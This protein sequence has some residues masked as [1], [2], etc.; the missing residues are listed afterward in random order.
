MSALETQVGGTHYTTAKD[1]IDTG[2]ECPSV[3]YK[4]FQVGAKVRVKDGPLTEYKIYS[5]CLHTCTAE[6]E[7]EERYHLCRLELVDKPEVCKLRGMQA[8]FIVFDDHSSALN[9]Q[10]GGTHYTDLK[11][12]P[13]EL[14]YQNFGYTG[15][16]AAIYTKVNKYLTRQKDDELEQLKKARHCIDLL[17]QFKMRDDT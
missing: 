12:Q 3:K 7:S 11:I 2:T 4:D 17:I 1:T 16:K 15:A 8:D 10:V 6:L 5:V 13:L 9:T 14:T